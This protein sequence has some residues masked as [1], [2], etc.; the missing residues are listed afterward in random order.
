MVGWCRFSSAS[1]NYLSGSRFA[2][3]AN[4][5]VMLPGIWSTAHNQAGL[6][7]L[8]HWSVSIH[9]EN[10]FAVPQYGLNAMAVAA[11]TKPGTLGFSFYYFGYSQYHEMKSGLAF[12]KQLFKNFSAGVQINY[13][14][15]FISQDYGRTSTV[16]VEG[17]F[18]AQPVEDF[19]IGC[20]IF[21][22]TQSNFNSPENLEKL[23]MIFRFGAGYSFVDRIWIGIETLKRTGFKEVWKLG[24][25]VEAINHLYLRGGLSTDPVLNTFGLGYE[26]VGFSGDMAFSFHPQLGF[27]PHFTLTYTFR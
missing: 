17:G 9:Y 11:P 3:L 13:H 14:T 22:P 1:E 8:R 6:A 18:M 4:A 19:F 25:E 24:L 10:R 2:A 20:H 23:P 21:N 27:T 12:S 15:I 26:V 7:Y 5:S 16:S